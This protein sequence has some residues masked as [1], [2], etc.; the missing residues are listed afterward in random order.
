M[1]F[2][3]IVVLS[4]ALSS[5]VFAVLSASSESFDGL[6]L[7][8]RTFV[9]VTFAFL[10]SVF[11]L[12]GY[13]FSRLVGVQSGFYLD[14][15]IA[16]IYFALCISSIAEI[17]PGDKKEIGKGYLSFLKVGLVTSID[18]FIGGLTVVKMGETLPYFLITL[19]IITA[20]MG[21]LGVAFGKFLKNKIKSGQKT[22]SATLFLLLT[23][24]TLFEIYAGG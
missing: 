15:F 20:V 10:H 8:K 1:D 22:V 23:L 4:V 18:A 24:K 5:D 9:V 17:K 7:K 21:G 2:F 13:C 6:G 3:D 11:A 14:Y 19:F 12:L 16:F